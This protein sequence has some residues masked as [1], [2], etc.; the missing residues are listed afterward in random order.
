MYNDDVNSFEWVI[1]CFV[2]VLNHTVEQAEQLSYLIHFKG[3]AIVKQGSFK[4][5]KPKKDA[6]C[7]CGLSAVIEE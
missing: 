6:L 4:E 2:K 7:D 1:N 3:K 5:L